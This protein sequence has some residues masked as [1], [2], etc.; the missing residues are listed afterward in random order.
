[1]PNPWLALDL[2]ADPAERIRQVGRAH[3]QFL[4]GPSVTGDRPTSG[5]RTVVADSWRR[6]AHAL[7]TAD[8]TAPIELSDGDLE[9]Y[10]AAHPL[11]RCCRSS[12]TCWAAWPTTAIT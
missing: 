12:A 8:S 6:S 1:M 3:E 2:G 10:R 5:V 11:A 9:A 4:N 7:H